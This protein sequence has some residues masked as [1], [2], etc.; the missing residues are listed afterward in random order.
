MGL[1]E[2]GIEIIAIVGILGL[3]I[4]AGWGGTKK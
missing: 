4:A 1:L 2:N 3:L